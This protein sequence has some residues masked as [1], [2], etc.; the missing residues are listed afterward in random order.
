MTCKLCH[1]TV[2]EVFEIFVLERADLLH[3]VA[4][5]DCMRVHITRLQQKAMAGRN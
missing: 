4:C 3:I 1:K 2:D 5:E